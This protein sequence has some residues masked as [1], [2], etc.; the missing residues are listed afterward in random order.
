MRINT[1]I[2]FI[3]LMLSIVITSVHAQNYKLNNYV[4]SS[5]GVVISNSDY[6]VNVTIGQPSIGNSSDDLYESNIGF[7]YQYS[8][9]ITDLKETWTFEIPKK[10]ELYQNFPN[11]FNPATKIRYSIAKEGLVTLKIFN[12]IGEEVAVL[13]NKEKSS[14]MYEIDFNAASIPSGVYFYQLKAADFIQTKK[15]ILIK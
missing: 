3:A 11:P 1:N 9:T 15:M 2:L 13:V 4:L 10:F 7:W 14:G 12:I 6:A 5:G 8:Q